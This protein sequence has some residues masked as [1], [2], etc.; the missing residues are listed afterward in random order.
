[1]LHIP[2]QQA[3]WVHLEKSMNKKVVTVL[4]NGRPLILSEIE[5]SDAI[6][7]TWFLGSQANEAI[8][9]LLCGIEN[10]SG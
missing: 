2:H 5:L 7:E 4:Y 9:R 1:M 10:L 3:A 8:A 6:L